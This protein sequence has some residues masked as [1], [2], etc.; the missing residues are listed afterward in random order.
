MVT[1]SYCGFMLKKT[2]LTLINGWRLRWF[3][4]NCEDCTLTYY[5]SET[6]KEP[7]GCYVITEHCTIEAIQD[8]TYPYTFKLDLPEKHSPFILAAP[9]M[10]IIEAWMLLLIQIQM[11]AIKPEENFRTG[12]SQD[13]ATSALSCPLTYNGGISLKDVTYFIEIQGGT[14]PED[15]TKIKTK[16]EDNM[17]KV[18][19]V[20][21][22]KGSRRSCA[23]WERRVSAVQKR[24]IHK[25]QWKGRHVVLANH[26]L[27]M[28]V[29]AGDAETGLRPR[30]T[31][32][33]HCTSRLALLPPDLEGQPYSLA[34]IPPNPPYTDC[35]T[36]RLSF[37][38]EDTLQ[39]WYQAL[40]MEIMRAVLQEEHR[41][42][43][44]TSIL[45]QA[46][47][48]SPQS[49][50]N[51]SLF[52]FKSPNMEALR[53]TEM[54]ANFYITNFLHFQPGQ[55]YSQIVVF[56][57]QRYVP[58]VGWS[59]GHLLLL[60]GPDHAKYTDMAGRRFPESMAS[61]LVGVPPPPSYKWA[62]ADPTATATATAA[63][64]SAPT[65]ESL[66]M[67]KNRERA[68]T[69][70]HTLGLQAFE[71]DQQYTATDSE[72]W[73][74]ASSFKRIQAHLTENSSHYYPKSSDFV[75]RRRWVR[76][77]DLEFD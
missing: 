54:Y 71:V 4:L 20:D 76:L 36:L 25:K 7:I 51:P 59:S 24:S 72:G 52:R 41:E 31:R 62:T 14:I 6:A 33:F 18:E 46:S 65:K 40:R 75:R 2:Q 60:G 45:P 42:T 12:E 23:G 43:A 22:E 21:G 77:V 26:V 67:S 37:R 50:T 48:H 64:A 69:L 8:T 56:E 38:D 55:K 9:N 63:T 16:E 13:A 28:Y 70:P 58:L 1:R 30:G 53:T 66:L 47:S 61:G 73:A 44:A 39:E 49:L 15:E 17:A 57:N 29:D 74:Y 68:A 32:S 5:D 27:T 10:A 19:E 11:G 35:V 3:E 34:L